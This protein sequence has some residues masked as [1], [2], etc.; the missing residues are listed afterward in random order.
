MKDYHFT[1]VF[2]FNSGRT[3]PIWKTW[4]SLR[5]FIVDFEFCH[6]YYINNEIWS[7]S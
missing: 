5:R 3:G 4:L 7:E 2:D 1:Q 6:L